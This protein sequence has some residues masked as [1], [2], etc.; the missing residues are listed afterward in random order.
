MCLLPYYVAFTWTFKYNKLACFD[1]EKIFLYYVGTQDFCTVWSH[2]NMFKRNCLYN[3]FGHI[4]LLY[5]KKSHWKNQVVIEDT[6]VKHTN[7]TT[8]RKANMR[9]TSCLV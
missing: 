7:I 2:E 5:Y 3:R 8:I 4:F 1:Y 9:N 6:K